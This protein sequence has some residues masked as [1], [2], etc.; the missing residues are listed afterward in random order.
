VSRQA[1]GRPV[2]AKGGGIVMQFQQFDLAEQAA[3]DGWS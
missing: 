2:A 1:D 3:L